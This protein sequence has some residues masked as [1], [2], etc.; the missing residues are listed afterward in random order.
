MK[1]I[2]QGASAARG[3]PAAGCGTDADGG[4]AATAAASAAGAI[5]DADGGAT[6]VAAARTMGN[7]KNIVDTAGGSCRAPAWPS[8]LSAARLLIGWRIG[9]L[10]RAQQ[11][12]GLSGRQ[13]LN[14]A[15]FSLDDAGTLLGGVNRV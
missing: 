1:C 7:N 10:G 3:G 2:F 5:A 13:L 9:G 14:L 8:Q 11:A 15:Q 6:A 12:S 4:G